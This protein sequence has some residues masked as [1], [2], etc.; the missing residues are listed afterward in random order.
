MRAREYPLMQDTVEAG[1]VSGLHRAFKHD[2]NPT[3][4]SIVDAIVQAVMSE[5]SERWEMSDE[6]TVE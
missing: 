5:I 3:Q 1:V 2:D 6:N 4:A